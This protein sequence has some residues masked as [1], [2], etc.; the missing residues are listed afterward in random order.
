MKQPL[1]FGS[2]LVQ[3]DISGIFFTPI[4][5]KLFSSIAFNPFDLKTNIKAVLNDRSCSVLNIPKNKKASVQLSS[6]S[7]VSITSNPSRTWVDNFTA[8]EFNSGKLS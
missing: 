8:Q 3:L 4:Y 1:K 5:R 7:Y 6:C 2:S